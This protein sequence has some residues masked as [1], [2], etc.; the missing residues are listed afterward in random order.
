MRIQVDPK[1]SVYM[2]SFVRQIFLHTFQDIGSVTD[3]HQWKN[4]PLCVLPTSSR[5]TLKIFS[6]WVWNIMISNISRMHLEVV[7]IMYTVWNWNCYELETWLKL[8]NCVQIFVT[9]ESSDII[10]WTLR[11]PLQTQS[12]RGLF[13]FW[14][15]NRW[16]HEMLRIRAC[17]NRLAWFFSMTQME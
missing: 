1:V 16:R 8:Y 3:G 17:N 6:A 9:E 5:S 7:W 11:F 13:Q 12:W 15:W 2:D 10:F 4:N 14:Q